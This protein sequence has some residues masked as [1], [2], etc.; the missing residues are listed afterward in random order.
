MPT[1]DVGPHYV[2]AGNKVEADSP[3]EALRWEIES[4]VDLMRD[5]SNWTVEEVSDDAS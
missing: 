4:A 1:Y 5:E 3:E 2:P